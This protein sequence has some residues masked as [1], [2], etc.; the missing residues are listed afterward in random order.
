MSKSI[1]ALL[2]VLKSN[3]K[4]E[5][6]REVLEIFANIFAN[7][8]KFYEISR[9]LPHLRMSFWNVREQENIF[10]STLAVDGAVAILPFM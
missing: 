1:Y 10:V 3:S 2:L 5:N 9:K 6:S 4:F 7:T 8:K